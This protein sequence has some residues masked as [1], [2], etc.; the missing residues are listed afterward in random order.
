MEPQ[1]SPVEE[2]KAALR[3]AGASGASWFYWIAGLSLVNTVI[4]FAGSNIRFVFGL[5]IT[6]LV[7]SLAQY[8]RQEQADIA[9][10]LSGI[11]VIVSVIAAGVL[12]LFGWLSHRQMLWAYATG[13][14]LYLCDGILCLIFQDWIAVVVHLI[15]LFLLF[16]GFLAYAQLARLEGQGGV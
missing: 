7:N 2:Q 5:G 3:Q 14:V 11:A 4:A 12:A 6:D 1:M 10:P 8:A 16:R 13:I 9:E 15:A